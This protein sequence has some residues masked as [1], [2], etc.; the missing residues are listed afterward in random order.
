MQTVGAGDQTANFVDKGQPALATEG[1]KLDLNYPRSFPNRVTVVIHTT[2][3]TA[4]S[5]F[6]GNHYLWSVREAKE[7]SLGQGNAENQA[8]LFFK[9]EASSKGQTDVTSCCQQQWQLS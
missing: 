6:R 5:R 1:K 9:K 8:F 2:R 3:F 4:V 7:Q